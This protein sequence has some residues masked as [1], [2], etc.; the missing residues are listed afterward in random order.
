VQIGQVG[1]K[2][3]SDEDTHEDEV[4][5]DSFQVVFEWNRRR[6]GGKFQIEI[7]S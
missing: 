4:I 3:V 5:D 6:E 7:F 1:Q 2:I